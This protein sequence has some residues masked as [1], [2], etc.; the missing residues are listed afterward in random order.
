VTEYTDMSV[1][2]YNIAIQRLGSMPPRI[3]KLPVDERGYPVPKFVRWIDGKPDFRIMDGEFLKRAIL[4]KLCWLCG[5]NLG[6]HRA[7]VIGSMCA[8]NRTSAEPPSHLDCARY[9]VRAC[10]F[11][12]QPRRPR[13]E[14]ELPDHPPAAGIM[15]ERNPGVSLIWVTDGYNIIKVKG[16]VLFRLNAREPTL[17]E[18]YAHARKATR[19]E[20]M[21]SIESGLP[22]L[23]AVAK[24][25]GDERALDIEIERGLKLVPA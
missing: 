15:L 21:A 4:Y 14:H 3:A 25:D 6:R 18:W 16:G 10:P 23:R 19:E 24:A 12:T 5:E 7:F 9:A 22:A 2:N 8:I 13:N 17:L 11:L 1:R 20:I